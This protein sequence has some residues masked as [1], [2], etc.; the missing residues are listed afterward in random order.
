[1]DPS[2]LADGGLATEGIHLGPWISL[3]LGLFLVALNGFF[4]AAEFALVKVRPTQLDPHVARGSRRGRAARHML[5]HLDAYLSASQLG[6]TLASLALGWIGEPAFAWL[7]GPVVRLI[8]GATPAVTS[9]VS[10]TIAFL[11]IT[12]LHIVIG[13]QAPKSWAIRSAETA[14]LAISLPLMLFYR[15]TYPVIWLLNHAA[16]FALRLVGVQ[17][18][19]EEELG[20]DEGELR[21]LLAS[22]GDARLS[23]QKRELLDNIFELSDRVARQIMLPRGDVVYLSTTRSL[24]ENLAVARDSGHTR[25][26]LCEGDLDHA[27]GLVHIKDLFRAAET[28]TSLEQVA[29][30]LAFVP[31]TLRL[32]RLLRRMRA[33]RLHMAAV[34][35]EYG[36]VAGIV[37]MENVIEEIVGSIQDEFD[38][39]KPE[40]VKKGKGDY[41]ISGGMLVDDLEQALGLELSDRDEDTIGG[42]VLSE[43]GRPP[44]LG[45]RVVLGPAAIEVLDLEGARITS[46]RITLASPAPAKA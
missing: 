39:E 24:A 46:V 5:S 27:V 11:I 22:A 6:I 45:D 8:P 10:I 35:D 44:V 4:V 20:Q 13:E 2:H 17:P 43:L 16:N 32:D 42:V 3:L 7:V 23:K 29:R 38:L 25:F 41:V 30:E 21:L 18:V 19:S 31:E 28:L 36:G 1:M 15:V 9:T 12:T 34:V 40:L 14:A 37:T 33:E 26:P